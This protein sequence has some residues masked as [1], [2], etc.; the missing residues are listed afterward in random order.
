VILADIRDLAALRTVFASTTPELVFHAAALKH[1]P[2]MESHPL[3]G[4]KTNVIGTLNV[5]TAAAEVAVGT[6]VNIS[7]DK[8]ANPSSVLG[9]TK[10][11]TE[12]LT[13]AFSRSHPGRYVSVRFGNVLGSRGSVVHVFTAQIERG[14]RLVRKCRRCAAQLQPSGEPLTRS[15]PVPRPSPTPPAPARCC[16]IPTEVCRWSQ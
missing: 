4:W 8:A 12:R 10:R 11:I 13:A 3:E 14:G 7:T 2:L 5:L 6:F 15:R 9:L 1:L 16:G